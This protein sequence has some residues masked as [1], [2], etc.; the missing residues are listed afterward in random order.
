MHNGTN[1]TLEGALQHHLDPAA[2]LK[3]YDPSQLALEF[4]ELVVND[5]ELIEA[6]LTCPSAPTEVLELSDAQIVDLLA[7]LETLTSPSATNL[8]HIVPEAVPSG[9]P[10][11]G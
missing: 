2:A 7:F 4:Q 9:L 11:G 8:A 1:T 5:P 6:Q 10:V 3:N